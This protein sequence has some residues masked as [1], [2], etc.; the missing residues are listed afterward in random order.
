MNNLSFNR[1]N[2]T[3]NFRSNPADKKVSSNT[4]IN[5]GTLPF[6]KRLNMSPATIGAV[7]GFC[8]FGVGMLLDKLFTAFSNSKLNT[9]ASLAIQGAFGAFMGYQAYKVAKN[10]AAQ[11]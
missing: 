9:K 2:V 10:E 11:S 3:P 1:L 4:S 7:N 8:W 5:G 6:T